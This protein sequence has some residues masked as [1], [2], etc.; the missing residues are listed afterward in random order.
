M[1]W[2]IDCLL[3]ALHLLYPRLDPMGS[4]RCGGCADAEQSAFDLRMFS[5]R[6]LDQGPHRLP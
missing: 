5:G 3:C 6:Q 1:D 2:F 4:I